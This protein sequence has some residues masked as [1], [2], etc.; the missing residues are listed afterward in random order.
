MSFFERR[1]IPNSLA[2]RQVLGRCLRF[3]SMLFDLLYTKYITGG[4]VYLSRIP[5]T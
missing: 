1:Y 2:S 3:V 5:G 4:N